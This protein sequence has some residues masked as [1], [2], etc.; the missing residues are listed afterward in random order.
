MKTTPSTRISMKVVTRM[1]KAKKAPA[2][3]RQFPLAD[4]AE[5]AEK[6]LFSQHQGYIIPEY[7]NANLIHTLRTYQDEAIRNYHYTQTQIKPNPQHVL[8]NMATGSG[9]TDLMAGL[10]L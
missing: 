8:F 2:N 10:I 4:Q 6:D 3:A 9:K 1:A 5:Q 7:I